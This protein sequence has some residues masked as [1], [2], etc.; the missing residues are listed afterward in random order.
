MCRRRGLLGL[1]TAWAVCVL[2]A[3]GCS[4]HHCDFAPGEAVGLRSAC[5]PHASHVYRRKNCCRPRRDPRIPGPHI[6]STLPAV[7]EMQG[8][9]YFQPVPTYPVFGPRSEE[10]DGIAPEMQQL[11][12]GDGTDGDTLPEPRDE[13]SQDDDTEDSADE[14]EEPGTLQLAAPNQSTRQ[15][16]WKPAQRQS[17]E[18]KTATR[19]CAKCTVTFKSRT[20][21]LR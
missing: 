20:S 18:T 4:L 1:A 7:P 15:A 12:P 10:P 3:A 6:V 5:D 16:G 17:V 19:P 11:M 2:T 8:P 14:D 13:V 9:S 21:P